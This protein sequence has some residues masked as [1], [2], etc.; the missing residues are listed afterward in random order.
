MITNA[1]AKL[2]IFHVFKKH[3]KKTRKKL[4]GTKF[5]LYFQNS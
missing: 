3:N 5:V 4:K 1:S 2:N